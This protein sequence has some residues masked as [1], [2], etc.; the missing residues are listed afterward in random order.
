MATGGGAMPGPD[1]LM[2]GCG[3][4]GAALV[5]GHHRA[6]ADKRI[7]ALDPDAARVRSLLPIGAGI[8]AISSPERFRAAP[9]P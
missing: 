3:S 6:D 2:I 9:Q 5:A 4:M 8:T 1:L 7:A